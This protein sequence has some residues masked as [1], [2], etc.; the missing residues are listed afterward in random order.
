VRRLYPNGPGRAGE[1]LDDQD[2]IEPGGIVGAYEDERRRRHDERPWVVLDMIASLDGATVI[3]GRSGGLGGPG[4][5]AVFSALRTLADIILVGASTVRAEGYRPPKK[6]GQ[7]IAVVSRSGHLDWSSELFTSGAGLAIV[8]TDGPEV[9]AASIRVG[10]GSVD[11]RAA[12]TQLEGDVVLCEGGPTLNGQ[13]LAAGLVDELCLSVAPS[14]VGGGAKR[15]VVGPQVPTDMTLVHV[16]EDEGF[17]FC[18]Y[19]RAP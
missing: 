13:L 1:G 4:D 9:P 18:R 19:V 15:I 5:R 11:L 6:T 10:E 7:R 12:L 8:P 17:L 3:D 16:L 14:L 2:L